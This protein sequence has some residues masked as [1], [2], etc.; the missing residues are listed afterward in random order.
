VSPAR[1]RFSVASGLPP[2]AE[3]AV[4]VATSGRQDVA[5]PAMRTRTSE[6]RVA[7]TWRMTAERKRAFD[8][9]AIEISEQLGR[10]KLDRAEMLDALA[11]L[12]MDN[13]GVRGA[14][15]ARLQGN[16]TS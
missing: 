1:K 14:L 11:D 3:E 10:A 9:M 6:G 12:A 13:P 15:I 8:R 16:K 4:D 5:T 2:S 7:F